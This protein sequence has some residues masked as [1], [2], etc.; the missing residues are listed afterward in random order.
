MLPR[1]GL[2][3]L[4]AIAAGRGGVVRLGQTIEQLD[5]PTQAIEVEQMLCC[6]RGRNLWE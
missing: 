5:D 1:F 6:H 2:F 3:R 4:D